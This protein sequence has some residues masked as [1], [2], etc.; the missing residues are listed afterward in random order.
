MLTWSVS[1][2]HGAH[3]DMFLGWIMRNQHDSERSSAPVT[4]RNPRITQSRGEAFDINKRW[5]D[6]TCFKRCGSSVPANTVM[7]RLQQAKSNTLEF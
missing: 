4:Q 7:F 3:P 6:V 1:V 5:F 2:W